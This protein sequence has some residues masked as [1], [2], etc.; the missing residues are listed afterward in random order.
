MTISDLCEEIDFRLSYRSDNSAGVRLTED[1][2]KQFELLQKKYKEYIAQHID[3]MTQIYSYP[4]ETGIPGY[5]VFWNYRFI[6]LS[7]KGSSLFIY[8]SASD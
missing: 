8:G 6:L 3:H 1:K 2:Q 7:K 5:L 4:D